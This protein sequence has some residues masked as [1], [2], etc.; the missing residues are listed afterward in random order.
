MGWAGGH[1]SRK[2]K[3]RDKCPIGAAHQICPLLS[4]FSPIYGLQKA[5]WAFSAAVHVPDTLLWLP[6]PSISCRKESSCHQ[7]N[8]HR[9]TAA[10]CPLHPASGRM[11]GCP[12][13]PPWSSPRLRN[14]E[15]SSQSSAPPG[16]RPHPVTPRLGGAPLLRAM[17]HSSALRGPARTHARPPPSPEARED[18]TCAPRNLTSQALARAAAPAVPE[19]VRPRREPACPSPAVCV[20]PRHRCACPAISLRVSGRAHPRA[21]APPPPK[22]SPSPHPALPRACHV[23]PPRAVGR[24]ARAVSRLAAR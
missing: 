13:A 4:A 1:S 8:P 12:G 17:P 21:L 23:G 2:A 15:P 6:H 18:A 24:R 10:R 20:R 3:S 5:L 14:P 19:S 16:P 22:T 9:G 11:C 7:L